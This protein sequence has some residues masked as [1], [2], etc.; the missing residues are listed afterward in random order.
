LPT[1]CRAP[2]IPEAKFVENVGVYMHHITSME[3][4]QTYTICTAIV[5]DLDAL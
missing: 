3:Y 4:T 5:D 1:T 2:P